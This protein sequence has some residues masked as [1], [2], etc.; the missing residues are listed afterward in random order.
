MPF[1]TKSCAQGLGSGLRI[2]VFH[3]PCFMPV[4]CSFQTTCFRALFRSPVSC[5]CF[6]RP[7]HTLLVF[8]LGRNGASDGCIRWVSG[9]FSHGEAKG[10]G[11]VKIWTASTT[12]RLPLSSRV[13]PPQFFSSISFFLGV[14]ILLLNSLTANLM[15]VLS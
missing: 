13:S 15:S 7:F 5:L 14:A 8:S 1:G 4:S 2:L 6:K 10:F 9:P 12:E 11:H 3:A